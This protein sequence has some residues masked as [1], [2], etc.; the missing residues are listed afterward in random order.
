MTEPS[1]TSP[2]ENSASESSEP[3]CG[4]R[5]A[6]ARR[7]QQ[8]TVLEVAKELH[9]DEPKVRALERNDF[10]MLGA[11][12]FAKGHLR[13]YA[14]LVGVDEDDVFTDYY[15]MTRAEAMPP[16]IARRKMIRQGISPG[17]WIAVVAVI[18]VAAIAYWWWMTMG[19]APAPVAPSQTGQ[20]PAAPLEEDE[21]L[22]PL[23]DE[24]IELDEFEQEQE[25]AV[26]PSEALQEAV[27]ATSA[28]DVPAAAN[29]LRLTLNFSGECWTEI[30]D[31]DGQR[32]FYSMGR[33]GQSVEL[34]G[35]AP[36]SALF[37]NA[38]NVEVTVNDSAYSL[39]VPESSNRT[40]RVA[41]LNQ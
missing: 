31:A 19:D 38:D 39:P 10:E 15:T 34:N 18:V 25:G 29:Q 36:I 1:E 21:V 20:T 28:R 23:Q 32:L 24:Q 3:L 27:V 8:I 7:E 6:E 40:V 2:E 11:P 9:L 17:P 35:K 16:I 33:D 13:K 37:G 26:A 22:Q 30:S 4:E 12:V 5:L 41:I 14:Q